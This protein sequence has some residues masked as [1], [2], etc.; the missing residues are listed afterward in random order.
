MNESSGMPQDSSGNNA[1]MTAIGVTVPQVLAYNQ[2]GPFSGADGIAVTVQNDVGVESAIVDPPTNTV[3]Y[4][5]PKTMECWVKVTSAP[6]TNAWTMIAAGTIGIVMD[7]DQKLKIARWANPNTFSAKS[8]T[9][10][11]LDEWY[12]VMATTVTDDLSDLDMNLYI[13]ET[14]EVTTTGDAL[15]WPVPNQTL[16]RCGF[17]G[18]FGE[19]GTLR[20]TYSNVALYDTGGLTPDLT[21]AVLVA[22]IYRRR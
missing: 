14:L 22:Q 9:A 16:I 19:V 3:N 21:P 18:E 17:T 15:P 13:N 12:F 4:A 1:D 11:N 5:H 6:T 20:A 8:T 2:G 10:L 7:T